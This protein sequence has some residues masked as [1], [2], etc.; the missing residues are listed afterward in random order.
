MEANID[1]NDN[2]VLTQSE[3]M[4]QD[5]YKQG[6]ILEEKKSNKY[7]ILSTIIVI[8]MLIVGIPIYFIKF[9]ENIDKKNK[10]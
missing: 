10:K 1:F 6:G 7:K 5:V 3:E 9:R 2:N 8:I 4:S